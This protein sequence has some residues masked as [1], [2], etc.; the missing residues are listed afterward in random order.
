MHAGSVVHAA[1]AAEACD[2]P[3]PARHQPHG[4]GAPPW[5]RRPLRTRWPAHATR[6]LA[7]CVSSA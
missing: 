6:V 7:R 5:L 2:L 4:Q 3:R 1:E